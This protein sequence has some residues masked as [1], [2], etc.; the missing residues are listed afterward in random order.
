[1]R[2]SVCICGECD[3]K[4]CKHNKEGVCADCGATKMLA[5]RISNG[6]V[7]YICDDCIKIF[8]DELKGFV[9]GDIDEN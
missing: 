1:M 2:Y 5:R 4:C 7:S 3:V 8:E 6:E 9:V